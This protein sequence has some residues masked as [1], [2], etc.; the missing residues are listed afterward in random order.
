VDTGQI[1]ASVTAR[2]EQ[3]RRLR[4]AAVAL[5]TEIGLIRESLE[6]FIRGY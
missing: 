1:A 2:A 4:R 6:K 3:Q 5:G